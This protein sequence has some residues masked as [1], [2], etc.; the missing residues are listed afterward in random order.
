M[1]EQEELRREK[2]ARLVEDRAEEKYHERRYAVGCSRVPE[3][4]NDVCLHYT[5]H[6]HTAACELPCMRLPANRRCV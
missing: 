6:V 2:A 5:E 1:S 3:C 4:T